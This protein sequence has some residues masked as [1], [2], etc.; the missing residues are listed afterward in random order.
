METVA[1]VCDDVVECYG[2]EDEPIICKKNNCNTVLGTSVGIILLIYL[3]LKFYSHY[4]RDNK[5][6]QNV[7]CVEIMIKHETD[8]RVLREEVKKFGLHVKHHYD[9]KTKRKV[10]LKIFALE[11]KETNAEADIFSRLK[12]FYHPEIANFVID[13]RFPGLV[14]K[15]LPFLQDISDYLNLF[16]RLHS[17]RLFVRK[18]FSIIS[19]YIDTFRDVYILYLILF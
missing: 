6:G 10:G 2:N 5:K 11:A 1:T 9:T 19:H 17:I 16:E 13:S 12:N 7:K 14:S 4:E 18:S 8:I 3:G 15:F